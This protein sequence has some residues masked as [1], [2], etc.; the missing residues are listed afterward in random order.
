MKVFTAPE[1]EHENVIKFLS[2]K[3]RKKGIFKRETCESLEVYFNMVR[4]FR[5]VKWNCVDVTNEAENI[6]VS[7][8]DE[9]LAP[10]VKDLDDQLLLWRPKYPS[11]KIMESKAISQEDTLEDIEF[12][13]QSAIDD[14]VRRRTESQE[15]LLAIDSDLHK[16]Q[17]D[18]MSASSLVLPRSPSSSRKEA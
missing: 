14:L 6:R 18:A 13:L 11:L 17:R 15:I 4:P 9:D 2:H 12:H 8:L 5:F 1:F 3:I 10:L 7:L 16:M